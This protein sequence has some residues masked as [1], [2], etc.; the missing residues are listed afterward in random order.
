[1]LR[2][3]FVFGLILLAAFVP[4]IAIPLAIFVLAPL[5]IVRA[6]SFVAEEIAQPLALVAVPSFR[7]PPSL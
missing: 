1:M 5:V 2:G 3:L 7:A 6:F 4:W